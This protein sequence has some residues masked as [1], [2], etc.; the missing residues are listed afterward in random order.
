MRKILFLLFFFILSK[1]LSGQRLYFVGLPQKILKHGDYRQNI[2]IGKY[3]YSRHNWE[4]AVEHFNQCSAL[5]RRTKHYSYLTRSYL[6]LNDLPNAKKALKRIR[7][8]KEKQ[9]LRLSIIE[10]SSYG[11]DPKFN[12]NNIDRIIMDRQY[13]IDKTKSNII[14]MA[15][16]HIPNFGD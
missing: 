12:K 13:V 2:E 8:R 1:G 11:K 16:N 9:L 10:I 7:S 14:A 3:Y 5:S 6:Y 15:K 4:K